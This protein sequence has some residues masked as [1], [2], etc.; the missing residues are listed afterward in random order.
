MQ[1]DA[2]SEIE[3]GENSIVVI[4]SNELIEHIPS[5]ADDTVNKTEES[6]ASSSLDDDFD[7][8]MLMDGMECDFVRILKELF[9]R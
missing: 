5:L 1:N 9:S 7:H 6:N 8:E 2:A 4:E 3:D